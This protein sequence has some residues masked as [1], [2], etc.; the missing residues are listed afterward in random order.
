MPRWKAI[1]LAMLLLLC[2][3]VAGR[4]DYDMAVQKEAAS[5]QHKGGNQ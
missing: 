1:L 3:G 5:H 4:M 2:M